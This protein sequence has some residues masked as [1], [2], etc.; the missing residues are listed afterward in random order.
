MV[1]IK[2]ITKI[3]LLLPSAALLTVMIITVANVLGRSMFKTPVIGA[4]EIAGL[5][6]SIVVSMSLFYTQLKDRNVATDIVFNKLP[7]RYQKGLEKV[8]FVLSVGV[9]G[10]F[11][12][13]SI[14]GVLESYEE[15]DVTTIL[16]IPIWPFT[17]SLLVGCVA[18]CFVLIGQLFGAI[19]G[20]KEK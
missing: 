1:V 11:I 12:Y 18:F 16:T 2:Y 8:I 17:M 10:L 9:V 20:D 15:N 6:G 7:K 5:F 14:L 4:I 19:V 13:S 3:L